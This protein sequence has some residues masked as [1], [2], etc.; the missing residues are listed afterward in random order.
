MHL[1]F[2]GLIE[3]VK[4][5]CNNSYTLNSSFQN[6]V[7]CLDDFWVFQFT[8]HIGTEGVCIPSSI[9]SVFCVSDMSGSK[10]RLF[11]SLTF[12]FQ[13]VISYHKHCCSLF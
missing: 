3:Y 6:F 7:I 9:T 1:T 8:N 13:L 4:I 11:L 5:S 10:S 12:C 2:L